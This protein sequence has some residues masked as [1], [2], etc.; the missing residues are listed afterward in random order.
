MNDYGLRPY[1]LFRIIQSKGTYPKITDT[2]SDINQ[3]EED[4]YG[5]IQAVSIRGNTNVGP[6]STREQ[7]NWD[8]WRFCGVDVRLFYAEFR[9]ADSAWT[10]CRW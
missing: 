8:T 4:I 3:Y 2:F 9:D 5:N 1:S 6:N 10:N 7:M